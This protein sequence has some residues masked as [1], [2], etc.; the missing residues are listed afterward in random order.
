M[1]KIKNKIFLLIKSVLALIFFLT[2]VLFFYAAFFFDKTSYEKEVVKKEI[3]QEQKLEE[4]KEEKLEEQNIKEE[5]KEKLKKKVEKIK[6]KIK[7]GIYATVGNKAITRSDIMNEIKSIL[8]LNNMSYNEDNRQDLT[9]AAVKE[10]VK[11]N[12]KQIEIDK[13]DFLK[14]NQIDLNFQ[15]ENLA[16]KAG[17]DLTS[18][19][20]ICSSNGLDFTVIENQ[21]KTELLWNSLIFQLYRNKISINIDEIDEKLRLNQ[22]KKEF[23]EYLISEIVVKAVDKDELNSMIADLKKKI[24]T[25]GFK[26]TA[27]KLSMSESST[28]GGDLGWIDESKLSTKLKS[29]IDETPTGGISK[30][31]LLKENILIFQVRDKRIIEK[32][33]DLEKL[34]NQLVQAEKNKI[35]NM[36]SRSHYENLRRLALVKFF[37]E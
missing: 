19:K 6:V 17:M 30:A 33:I 12:I 27:I 36:Y 29:I 22:N 20:D 26:N 2:V 13:N 32:K 7:D 4:K 28:N 16:K 15:L 10:V 14:F 34:K 31:I 5:E 35:L 37:N 11:R 8:I 21:M 24:E 1:T 18:L 25:E 23:K 9:R 3:L